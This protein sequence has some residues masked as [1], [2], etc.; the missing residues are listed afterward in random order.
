MHNPFELIFLILL[1]I[2][3]LGIGII[4]GIRSMAFLS[5]HDPAWVHD[6]VDKCYKN[7]KK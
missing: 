7:F 1:I 6:W 5:K 3:M 2:L 4:L